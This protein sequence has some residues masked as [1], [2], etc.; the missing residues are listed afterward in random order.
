MKSGSS[1][2]VVEA[3]ASTGC[4]LSWYQPGER[5][6][7]A[8]RSGLAAVVLAIACSGQAAGGSLTTDTDSRTLP[9]RQQRLGFL[10]RYLHGCRVHHSLSR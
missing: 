8:A 6:R 5:L 10:A 9:D 4:G 3:P 2:R 7:A 1:G